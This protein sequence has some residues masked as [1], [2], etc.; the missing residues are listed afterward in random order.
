MYL[1][2]HFHEDDHQMLAEFVSAHGF[3][4]LSVNGED[5]PFMSHLPMIYQRRENGDGVIRCHVARANPIWK[6]IEA[7]PAV[8]IAFTG[9]NAY[10]SPDWY[11]TPHL[12]P[13]WN[14]TAVYIQGEGRLL[15]DA[16]TRRVLEDL[17]DKHETALLPKPVWTLN[18]LDEKSIN[19]QLKAIVGIEIHIT[20]IDGKFKL[21]QNRAGEDAARVEEALRN[22]GGEN[23]IAVADMMSVV[24]EDT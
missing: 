4:V 12:V 3:G 6:S 7:N 10:V 9:P 14:Y 11:V 1:P 16:E 15:D 23:N 2:K 22:L 5:R 21:S 24:R 20:A 8:S 18:K 13:T 17:S 19:R